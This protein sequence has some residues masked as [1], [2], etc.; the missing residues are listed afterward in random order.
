M[1]ITVVHEELESPHGLDPVFLAPGGNQHVTTG[2]RSAR[3]VVQKVSSAIIQLRHHKTK[4][5]G[6]DSA[7]LT[8]EGVTTTAPRVS[9]RH[10]PSHRQQTQFKSP[11]LKKWPERHVQQPIVEVQPSTECSL[12]LI[13][14]SRAWKGSFLGGTPALVLKTC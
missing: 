3:G 13:R 10:H 7:G 9:T 11:V 2:G 5:L 14:I 12:Y 8:V 1:Y 4:P 6:P